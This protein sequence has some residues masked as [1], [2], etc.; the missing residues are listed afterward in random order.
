MSATTD[1]ALGTLGRVLLGGV[2]LLFALGVAAAVLA[3]LQNLLAALLSLLVT[4]LLV[5]GVGYALYWAGSTL[6]GGEA[7]P[8]PV[9]SSEYGP[10]A[11]EDAVDRLTEKYR[12]GALTEAELE[13]ELERVM[14]E[15]AD[16]TGDPERESEPN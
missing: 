2:A 14:D 4:A 7:T 13:R 1:R 15:T 8:E 12:D 5:V 16:D 10:A 11:D 6:L 3:V 9:E